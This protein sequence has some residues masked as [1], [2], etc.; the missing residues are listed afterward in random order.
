MLGRRVQPVLQPLGE[1][2]PAVI[3]PE[4]PGQDQGDLQ[5][6]WRSRAEEEGHSV[7]QPMEGLSR[8]LALVEEVGALDGAREL[9]GGEEAGSLEE[10]DGQNDGHQGQ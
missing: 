6:H 8:P 10:E 2:Q 1:E 9:G 7:L 3:D 5:Q 4:E